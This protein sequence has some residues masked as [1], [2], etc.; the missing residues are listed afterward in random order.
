MNR[1]RQDVLNLKAAVEATMLKIRFQQ[2]SL[3]EA[4]RERFMELLAEKLSELYPPK[5]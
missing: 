5:S 4:L 1:A 3:P 2:Q